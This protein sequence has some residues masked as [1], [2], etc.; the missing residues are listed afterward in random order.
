M[1]PSADPFAYPNQPMTTLENR[2]LIKSE[3]GFDVN[4]YDLSSTPMMGGTYNN[5]PNAQIY[6][7][8]PPY[9]MQGQPGATVR[10]PSTPLQTYYTVN[11]PNLMAMSNGNG[12]W[13][14]HRASNGETQAE[15]SNQE[16]GDWNNGW[17][18]Q[19]YSR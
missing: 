16:F 2:N 3:E 18:N 17:M 8:L 15:E 1:F 7:P 11:D 9:L 10:D 14:Q 19:G 5:N 6:G 4:M 12:G 13:F